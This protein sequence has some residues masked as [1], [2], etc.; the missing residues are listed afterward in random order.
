MSEVLFF[1][2]EN[3]LGAAIA[4]AGGK[5]VQAAITDAEEQIVKAAIETAAKIDEM[6]ALIQGLAGQGANSE[7][8]ALYQAAREVAGL[9]GLANLPDL[10][11]AA[12]VFCMQIDLALQKGALTDEQVMV[13]LGAL[14]LLRLPERFSA[15]ERGAL[16]DNLQAVLEK[17]QKSAA[18]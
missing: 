16:L 8:T 15:D 14:R 10:G 12:H 13:N 5:T 7:L 6:I 1:E 17:A 2:P 4:Q 9:A 18:P 11:R 3:R